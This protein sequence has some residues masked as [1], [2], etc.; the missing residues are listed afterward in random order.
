[1][2]LFRPANAST[3]LTFPMATTGGAALSGLGTLTGTWIAWGDTA[4]PKANGNPGFQNLTGVFNEIAATGVYTGSLAAPELPIASPYVL[5]AFVGTGAA[6]QYLLINTASRFVNVTAIRGTT[7]AAPVTAGYMPVDVKQTLSLS[8]PA[9]NSIEKSLAR[10]YFATAYLDAA[11]S[12]IPTLATALNLTAP[13]DNT[14]G[15]ALSR[16]YFATAFLD[17]AVSSRSTYAGADTAG[18]TTLLTRLPSAL[19]VTSGAVNLNEGQALTIP[20]AAGGT[21]GRALVNMNYATVYLDAQLSTLSVTVA[22]GGIATTSFAAGAIDAAAI[23][24]NAIGAAEL[25]ADGAS[26]YADAFLGRT[27]DRSGSGGR[28]V[29]QALMALRN[30]INISSGTLTVYGVNDTTAEW[31]ATIATE[32]VSAIVTD[33]NPA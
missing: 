21:T 17:A 30:R 6:T 22:A 28:T 4:G 9:D 11:V 2:E 1:M 19:T 29:G 3:F 8:A 27:I 20:S 7:V 33:I 23:A 5:C 10:A 13:T 26:E 25:A 31:T 18:T 32:A 14:V 12:G 24:S 15:K 16:I